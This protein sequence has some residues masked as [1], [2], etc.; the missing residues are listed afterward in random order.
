MSSGNSWVDQQIERASAVLADQWK[1]NPRA[2][3]PENDLHPSN[4]RL[5]FQLKLAHDRLD[6]VEN[7]LRNARL[8]R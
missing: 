3:Q 5:A 2:A 4:D 7:I 1:K 8:M 6:A